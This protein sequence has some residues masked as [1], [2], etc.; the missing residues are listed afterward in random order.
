MI[1]VVDK[2]INTLSY[3][4]SL[5][6]SVLQGIALNHPASK[7]YL[8]R[9][10][11]LEVRRAALCHSQ[12]L[13]ENIHKILLDLLL[14]SRHIPSITPPTSASTLPAPAPLSSTVIDTLLCVMV[15]S[16]AALRAFEEA[17]GL[18]VI[19]KILKRAGTPR[20]VR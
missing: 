17:G 19:V 3:H 14:A 4:V 5:A 2:E 10:Y 12:S 7:S 20:E 6:L 8:G 1:A 9:K 16:T 13:T 15:D 18:Q 11:S